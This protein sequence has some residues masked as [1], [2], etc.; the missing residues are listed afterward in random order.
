MSLKKVELL[1]QVPPETCRVRVADFMNSKAT[2]IFMLFLIGV[3]MALVFVN[4]LLD[5]NCN[6]NS[7][8]VE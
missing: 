3:Y 5:D 4:A 2:E 1:N 8:A 7:D 6:G